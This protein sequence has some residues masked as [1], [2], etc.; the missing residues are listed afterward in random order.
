[1]VMTLPPSSS[2]PSLKM[3]PPVW[4]LEM[5]Y[6]GATGTAVKMAA[7]FVIPVAPVYALLRKKEI[8]ILTSSHS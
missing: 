1:M 4:A 3:T 5:L 6:E 8:K 2:L 7:G